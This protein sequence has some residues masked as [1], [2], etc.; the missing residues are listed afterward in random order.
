M[1]AAGFGLFFRVARSIDV[2]MVD[3]AVAEFLKRARQARDAQGLGAEAAAAHAGADIGRY[4]DQAELDGLSLGRVD[5]M[6]FGH[7]NPSLQE[8]PLWV[9]TGVN[10]TVSMADTG[11]NVL[12]NMAGRMT[13]PAAGR[14]NHGSKSV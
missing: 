9:W 10:L 3:D 6:D 12:P 5:V 2:A 14:L 13:G 4:A 7:R 11:P 8:K 1:P